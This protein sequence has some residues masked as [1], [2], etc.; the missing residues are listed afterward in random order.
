MERGHEIGTVGLVHWPCWPLPPPRRKWIIASTICLAW[1]VPR[2]RPAPPRREPTSEVGNDAPPP[3]P[4]DIPAAPLFSCRPHGA[5]RKALLGEGQFTTG[6][7]FVDQ[8]EYRA[9]RGS[10]GY[11]WKAQ[12]W[13]GGDIDRAVLTTE[14][15][16]EFDA[17]LPSG[18]KSRCSGAARWVPGSIW[19]PGCATIS[20]PIRSG[21]MPCS[22][23]KGTG[24]LLDRG[25]R[26]AARL[27][28]G[29][30]PCPAGG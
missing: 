21:L 5:A 25:G 12:A 23:S 27:E 1:I 8:L 7:L 2:I 28:Q 4:T 11:G 19:K 30:C 17:T 24:A 29:R 6:G 22:A 18:P 9:L 13:Y 10:D 14:G 26:P 20:A 3:V 16:G 15:E